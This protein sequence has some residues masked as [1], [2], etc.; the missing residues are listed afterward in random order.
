MWL[1]GRMISAS[2]RSSDFP[3]GWVSTTLP[4]TAIV[5][6][7][8]HLYMKYLF[9]NQFSLIIVLLNNET[10]VPKDLLIQLASL[11]WKPV[12]QQVLHHCKNYYM[13]YH[14]YHLTCLLQSY[15][16]LNITVMT[17]RN[18]LLNKKRAAH[19]GGKIWKEKNLYLK[20]WSI[21]QV[22]K[23]S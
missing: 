6:L 16:P 10:N 8:M 2:W 17:W 9:S 18:P 20:R 12:S 5:C 23:Q 14:A 3:W 15:L 11:W 22:R 13:Q 4:L 1:L 19:K 7:I 21:W